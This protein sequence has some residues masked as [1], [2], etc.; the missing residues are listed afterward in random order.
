MELKHIARR[1]ATLSAILR[2]DMA[3]SYGLMNRLKW[4][5]KLLVNGIPQRTNYPV[6]A[7]DTVSPLPIPPAGRS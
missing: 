3:M 5:E 6:R 2:E 4:D 7:G 1:D